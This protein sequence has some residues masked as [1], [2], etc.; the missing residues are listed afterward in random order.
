MNGN[1]QECGPQRVLCSR[2]YSTRSPSPATRRLN[3]AKDI[4]AL[5]KP[6]PVPVLHSTM[7]RTACRAIAHQRKSNV[8]SRHYLEWAMIDRKKTGLTYGGFGRPIID[9]RQPSVFEPDASRWFRGQTARGPLPARNQGRIKANRWV[10]RGCSTSKKPPALQRIPVAGRGRPDGVGTQGQDFA[11]RD[12]DARRHSAIDLVW[13]C[14]STTSWCRP[15]AEPLSSWII[16]AC[17]KLRFPRPP[18]AIGGPANRRGLPGIWACAPDRRRDRRKCPGLYRDGE[19]TIMR[20]ASPVGGGRTAANA[21][22]PR[23]D[24]R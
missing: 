2:E 10:R 13:R 7:R 4:P 18:P 1:Q 15:P 11:N 14:R 9:G 16:F 6:E 20:G 21:L 17:G 23:G 19:L 8:T 3:F 22:L 5:C 24:N 12:R